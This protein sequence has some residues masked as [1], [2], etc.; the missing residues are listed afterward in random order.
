M[1]YRLQDLIDME[2]F[3]SLQDRLNEIY[4]FPS[5]IIDNDGNILTATAWQD[6][7]TK[8]HR[9][10]KDSKRHCIQSDQYILSHIHEANPTVSYRCP[11]GMVDNATPIII[12]GIHY[13]N[14]FTG[15][16]FLEEPDMNFFRAQAR[17]YGFEEEA[18]LKAVKKVPIWKKEQLDNYLFFIRGLIAI[19]SESGL[20]RLKEIEIQKQMEESEERHRSII[21]T[22][23]DGF[24]L[25]DIKGQLLEVNESY[26][27]MSGYCED[28]LLTMC[29]A[30]LE[31]NESRQT[32]AEH[33]KKVVSQGSDLFESKHRRKDGTVYDVEVSVQFRNE[34]GGRCVSFLRN[35]TDRK[36][37]EA[38]LRESEKKF[39][40]VFDNASDPI[41]ILNAH[42]RMLEVNSLACER[43]GYTHSELMSMTLDKIDTPEEARHIPERVSRLMEFGQIIFETVHQRRDGFPIPTEVSARRITWDDQPAVISICRDIS[44]RKRAMETLQKSEKKFQ[45]VFNHA[46]VGVMLLDSQS[47][48]LDCNQHLITTY[49]AQRD[50]YIG[51]NLLENMPEGPTRQYL[52]KALSSDTGVQFYE[53]LGTKVLDGKIPYIIV[54]SEKIEPDLLVVVIMDITERKLMEVALRESEDKFRSLIETTDTGY[55]ILDD[56]GLVLDANLKYVHLAGRQHF[57]KVI[58]HSVL[59]WTAPHDCKR[60]A[61]EVRKCIEQGYVRN[62]EIDYV[63][64]G[65]Q[66]I[67]IE[68]NATVLNTAGTI[69]IVTLC[70]DIIERKRAEEQLK[71]SEDKFSLTF[72][73]SPDAVNI[74]RLE[75]GLCVDINEGF[76]RAIGY[77]RDDVIGKTSLELNI[78]QDPADR[79]RLVQG[80]REKGYYEN[81]E[82]QFRKK[83]GSLITGLMSAR[84]V[85]LKGVPH[86]ISITRDITEH[87][88]HENEMLKIEKLE[89]L[90][91]LAGGIAHDFNNILTGIM[92][93]IS[94]AKIFL[95]S[96]HESYKPLAEAERATVRAGELAH[97]LLTFARGGEPVKKVVSPQRLVNEALSFVLRGSNV[98]GTINIPDSIHA[99]EAD[100][101]Q[102]SQVFRNIIINATQAM[103]EGGVVIVTAQNV[104]LENNNAFELPPGPYIRLTFADQ[105]CG[106]SGDNLK[107]IFDPY[108]TTKSDGIGLGLSSVHSI[109]NR[110]GG[111]IGVDSTVNK[112]TIITLHL[113]SI[114]KVFTEYREDTVEQAPVEYKGGSILVMDDDEMIRAVASSMLTH[115]G[116]EVTICAGGE[117]AVE[118]YKTS[119]ESGAPFEMAILDLT[120]P[121]GLGGKQAAEQI[122]SFYPKACLVVSSGYSNDPIMSNYREHGFSGAIAK[123]YNIHK[124]KEV[125]GV[126]LNR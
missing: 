34:K 40:L 74:N 97:Q 51:M 24:C 115:L 104:V 96:A 38:S 70:R 92:G 119:V 85:S 67:P 2:H 84:V 90:G 60:N 93:N 20:K 43:L 56:Q 87:K 106:I 6:I 30:D 62:L 89:S 41:F 82:A 113:P 5:A 121:G 98:K 68:I 47:V 122:L 21:Q 17:K 42:G 77:T 9:K 1:K 54:V 23:M 107:R 53:G 8:F 29:I 101:G 33:M 94:F 71:E 81:L 91:V 58:G 80:L 55:V 50:K 48:V 100:E 3:Q 123:P 125:L 12:D 105:G 26:C 114:G 109:V 61:T 45:A 19:I 126:L 64:S 95:D 13:G 25:T 7:C 73:C 44:E 124:F 15:Q 108:F 10:N 120:I 118:L 66:V 39:R 37:A 46:P 18:Y 14:F 11:H 63:H 111:H 102:I 36:L 4:S 116:Y 103:P 52:L 31:A 69:R 72:K 88:K 16:F 76:T 110:H 99:F 35:I 83:D 75:D 27:R 32:A 59:E 79:R 78:W 112:G 117:E 65:G 28:E 57:E 86:I 49:G 22:A